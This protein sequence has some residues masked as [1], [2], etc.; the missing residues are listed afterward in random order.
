MC[1]SMPARVVEVTGEQAASVEVGGV[2]RAVSTALLGT[3]PKPGDWLVVHAGFALSVLDAG[4]AELV[5]AS[6]GQPA[7]GE[8]LR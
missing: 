2:R 7:D 8:G 5:F 3:A 6:V 1:L 4:E